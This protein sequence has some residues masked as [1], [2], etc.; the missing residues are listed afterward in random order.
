[1]AASSS[2]ERVELTRLAWE[3]YDA[4]DLERVLEIFDPDVVIH[5][6]AELGNAGTYRGH[7][8]FLRWLAAWNEAWES[9]G[10][11]VVETVAVGDR[12]AVSNVSETG[13]GRGSG[14][15]VTRETGWL[16]EVRDLRCVYIG[17]HTDFDTGLAAAREREGI[18]VSSGTRG[19]SRPHPARDSERE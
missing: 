8:E 17:L 15:E 16:F 1:M 3:A 14:V 2:E 4:G 9:F 11:R 6:P 18:E 7:E 12:H 10:I 5:V 13:I 19:G